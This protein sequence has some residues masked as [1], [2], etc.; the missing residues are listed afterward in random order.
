M[1]HKR[2]EEL[3]LL[4]NYNELTSNEIQEF[5]SHLSVCSRCR[6][7]LEEMKKFNLILNELETVQSKDTLLQE[8]RQALSES[9]KSGQTKRSIWNTIVETIYDVLI[10]QYKIA[11]GSLA[12][13]GVGILIGYLA[14]KTREVPLNKEAVI[15]NNQVSI[16]EPINSDTRISNV[17][18]IKSDKLSGEIE[19]TLD[20]IMPVH[21]KGQVSD[22]NIQ[23]VL[24]YA[25]LSDLN[26]GVRL[27]SVNA[28][29]SDKRSTQPD[30]EVM[31]ALI[32]A[33]RFDK[34]P[35]VRKEALEALVQYSANQTV[36]Q[37]LLDVL[38]HD[39]NSGLRIAAIDALTKWD[40]RTIKNDTTFLEVLKTK[41]ITDKNNYIRLRSQA[42]LKEIVQ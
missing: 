26:P 22:P 3:L 29:A 31:E 34:N 27:Q 5:E 10:P 30:A 39:E 24:A 8:A 18:F 6:N 41:L 28:L 38:L 42:V 21:M 14:F 37:A 32:S 2:F 16:A 19:F 13:L 15:T 12:F 7:E 36:K 40:G 23:K 33:V 11:F 20:A 4:Y 1:N 17:Q 35:G 9:L 25:L